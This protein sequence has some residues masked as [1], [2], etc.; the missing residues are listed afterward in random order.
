MGLDGTVAAVKEGHF[1]KVLQDTAALFPSE[2][3]DGEL[4]TD[5]AAFID[6]RTSQMGVRL[7]CAEQSLELDDV[8]KLDN[9]FEYNLMRQ[10][11]G[12]AESSREL[13]G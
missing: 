4:E 8:E 1:Y 10:T 13:G 2:E 5:I 12:I 3:Y 9:P 6:P 7:L 11:L